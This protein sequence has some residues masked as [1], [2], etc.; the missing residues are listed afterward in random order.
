[1]LIGIVALP[2]LLGGWPFTLFIYSVEMRSG[3]VKKLILTLLFL[4]GSIIPACMY[5]TGKAYIEATEGYSYFSGKEAEINEA[6][7]GS[8]IQACICVIYIYWFPGWGPLPIGESDSDED[9][10]LEV[11]EKA[12][13]KPKQDG[14][15]KPSDPKADNV[16][17]PLHVVRIDD[18][19]IDHDIEVVNLDQSTRRRADSRIKREEP[20]NPKP[21]SLTESSKRRRSVT[22]A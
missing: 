16:D 10:D 12:P 11:P 22:M 5:F 21:K 7:Y 20:D 18:D 9:E 15:A 2:P 19:A 17:N 3:V 4:L 13:P 6:L 14:K 8:I 1:M